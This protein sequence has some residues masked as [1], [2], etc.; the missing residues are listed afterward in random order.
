MILTK[1]SKG[2]PYLRFTGA[3]IYMYILKLA[4]HFKA[5]LDALLCSAIIPL[6]LPRIDKCKK[7]IVIHR[8]GSKSTSLHEVQIRTPVPSPQGFAARSAQ[9]AHRSPG[10]DVRAIPG[11]SRTVSLGIRRGSA[12]A[13]SSGDQVSAGTLS[14]SS[15]L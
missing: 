3:N 7:Q 1:F 14:A 11:S 10:I 4:L 12:R 5:M 6:G 15:L 9:T 2:F 8:I 13:M